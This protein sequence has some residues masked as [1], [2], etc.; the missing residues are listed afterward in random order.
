MAN[1]RRASV[2]LGNWLLLS[3]GAAWN[4]HSS[5]RRQFE[6]YFSI[7]SQLFRF[8]R[9]LRKFLGFR[10]FRILWRFFPDVIR[11]SKLL[12][13]LE[14]LRHPTLNEILNPVEV[15]SIFE[16]TKGFVSTNASLIEVSENS[17]CSVA[18]ES[19]A[20]WTPNSLR[21]SEKISAGPP[22]SR[23]SWATTEYGWPNA[24]TK[25]LPLE[26]ISLD[27]G[28]QDPRIFMAGGK[29]MILAS[30]LAKESEGSEYWVQYLIELEQVGPRVMR[31]T[32]IRY[33]L[34]PASEKNWMPL[35]S[36]D[37]A[38]PTIVRQVAPTS[39]IEI[40]DGEIVREQLIEGPSELQ[41]ARGGTP[42]LRTGNSWVALVHH[43][44][45]EP[46]RFY[47]HR[48]VE[49]TRNDFGFEVSKYSCEFFL[50]EVAK[51]EFATGIIQRGDDCQILFGLEERKT[52]SLTCNLVELLKLLRGIPRY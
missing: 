17:I 21:R 31:A 47:T 20:V 27:D 9:F 40:L 2:E 16:A 49:F 22:R 4:S 34:K 5:S 14:A 32:P 50:S 1:F 42:L 7:G 6:R 12:R 46:L 33:G 10:R 38:N 51:L 3:I 36:S 25:L 19:T 30:R 15:E 18:R 52:V 26:G 13:Q 35:A 48:L 11:Q 24:D 43:T 28:F 44:Y 37:V 45:T 41:K 23:I 8:L 39:T 29:P